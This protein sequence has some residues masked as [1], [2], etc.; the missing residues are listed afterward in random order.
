[1]I[2]QLIFLISLSVIIRSLFIFQNAIS[3]HYDMSRDAFIARSILKGDLKIQGPPTSTPGLY[4]GVLYY[5]LIAPFYGLG[6]GDPKVVSTALLVLSSLSIIPIYLIA[7]DL[8]KSQFWAFIS[9]LFFVFSSEAVQYGPWL[10]NPNPSLTTASYFFYGLWLWKK[11]NFWGLPLAFIF[12]ALSMQFQFFMIYLF[13]LIILFKFLFNLPIYSKQ[14]FF[15]LVTSGVIL[16]SFLLSIL[17]FGTITQTFNGLFGISTNQFEWRTQFTDLFFNYFNRFVDLYA[18]NFV[19]INVFLGGIL[20]VVAL[21]YSAKHKFLLFGLLSTLPIFIF[22][23]HNSAFANVGMVTPVMLS[24]TNLLR[25][26][27]VNNKGLFAFLLFMILSLS[28]Y[29]NI[30]ISTKGQ[31]VLVIPKDMVLSKQLALI[32]KTYELANGQ[33]F[34]INSLTLPLWT[35]TTW[36]Y[37]YSWYGERNYGYVPIF[38]GRDQVGSPGDGVLQETNKPLE[39]S[40]FI[41]EPGIGIPG[42]FINQEMESENGKTRFIREYEFGTLKLQERTPL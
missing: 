42:V 5:Y 37:L 14:V 21:Y 33:P 16:S 25:E 20:A 11:G 7:K 31:M 1:M 15:S 29:V 6:N 32:D 35:N 3:F 13:V 17:K 22:G 40:F 38:Y 23:G 18:N 30:N 26:I 10:S 19:P 9:G 36:A 24:L 2:K 4:H 8:F 28:L 12:A 39:K 34:S 41:V 27:S